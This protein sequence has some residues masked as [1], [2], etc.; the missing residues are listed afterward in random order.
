MD[1]ARSTLRTAASLA[2]QPDFIIG[3]VEISPATRTVRSGG[4]TERIEPRVMQVLIALAEA[5]NEVLTRD[6]L[7]DRCWGGVYVG[8]DSLNRAIAGVRRIA[9]GIGGRSFEVETIPRTGYRLIS[10]TGPLWRS[11]LDAPFDEGDSAIPKPSVSRRWLIAGGTAAFAS[12]ALVW[13][14]QM[15]M[16]D[17]A[18]QFIDESRIAMRAGSPEAIQRAIALLERAVARAPANAEAWGLL[19]LA[20]ARID[21]HSL[22]RGTISRGR[23]E[24]AASRALHLD[25][26]NADA[27]AALA[28]SIPYYGAW[29]DAERRFDAI[30]AEHPDHVFT[31][32]SRLFLLGAVG[33]M[34]ESGE[35]REKLVASAPFDAA[36][37]YKQVY[38]LWFL[39]RVPEADRV[40][41]R[42]LEMWPRDPG[43]WF[44]R[45]WILAGTGRYD[46]ALAHVAD[47]N[48]RPALPPPMF[49]TL[50]M[51]LEAADSGRPAAV[52]A[53][54]RRILAGVAQS[55]AAVVN[56]L[57]LL[58]IM[59]AVDRAFELAEAYYLERGP[60]LAAMQWRPGQPYVP[61]Q[62]R[63]KTN[64]LFV[65]SSAAMQRDPRFVPMMQEIG[66]SDYWAARGIGPDFLSGRSA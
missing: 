42:G 64:M 28:I 5:C 3:T 43:T 15:T 60:V 27:K 4:L 32:D 49:E 25:A 56:G 18:A 47:V 33:R 19:A 57:M 39:G 34:K 17:P 62:R 48:A 21:E 20:L 44:A 7:F 61:D 2:D 31:R 53:A 14:L 35:D 65:P 46:R 54:S 40:A 9:T 38:S 10:E 26:G 13:S 45:L 6:A 51:A 23:I 50:R 52:E 58:N 16:P 12:A 63:R 1:V 24:S 41:Q 55:V 11:E 8:D 66:L 22:D 30:L 29:L 37:T 59:G 36:L